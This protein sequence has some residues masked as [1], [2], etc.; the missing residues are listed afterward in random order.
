MEGAQ[1][2]LRH[3]IHSL[4]GAM[5]FLAFELK[6]FFCCW[7]LLQVFSLLCSQA[8]FFSLINSSVKVV[9]NCQIFSIILRSTATSCNSR[10][11]K[12]FLNYFKYYFIFW[13]VIRSLAWDSPR[14][15]Y[16]LYLAKKHM[17]DFVLPA[18]NMRCFII[19]SLLIL[20]SL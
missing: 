11:N 19:I 9:L 2:T 8:N 4:V 3:L 1:D 16:S 10:V 15:F 20:L 6:Q 17:S 18:K 7:V 12:L 5:L 14:K 13:L